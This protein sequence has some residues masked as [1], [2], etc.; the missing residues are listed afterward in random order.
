[1]LH[2]YLLQVFLLLFPKRKLPF[3]QSYRNDTK[4]STLF[5]GLSCTSIPVETGGFCKDG[6]GF[7]VMSSTPGNLES[8]CPQ[9]SGRPVKNQ[10]DRKGGEQKNGPG[11]SRKKM[12]GRLVGASAIHLYFPRNPPLRY[13]WTCSLRTRGFRCHHLLQKKNPIVFLLRGR[14]LCSLTLLSA[15]PQK[16]ILVGP[17]HCNLLCKDNDFEVELCCCRPIDS[18]NSCKKVTRN[19]ILS[20]ICGFPFPDKLL[21]WERSSASSYKT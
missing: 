6:R 11:L 21:L 14:H 8:A 5:D 13:P 2:C 4:I 17:A 20:K 10:L 18:G 19:S 15:P 7:C 3:T 12:G 16:T 9:K 1:M